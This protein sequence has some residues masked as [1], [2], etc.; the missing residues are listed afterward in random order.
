MKL[1]RTLKTYFKKN[2]QEI[3]IPVITS[4]TFN[5]NEKK[6]NIDIRTSFIKNAVINVLIGVMLILGLLQYKE[7]SQLS[8]SFIK[9]IE[10]KNQSTELLM[11]QERIRIIFKN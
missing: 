11:L 10:N 3:E 5:E 7:D 4:I 6:S 2:L 9:F 8:I 1:Q